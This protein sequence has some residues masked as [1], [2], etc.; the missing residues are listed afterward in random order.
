M[1][2]E[3]KQGDYLAGTDEN[4][5]V[6]NRT[7][8]NRNNAERAAKMQWKRLQR[9]AATF[10]PLLAGERADLYTEM[11]DKVSGFEQP[12]DDAEWTIPRERKRLVRIRT[13]LLL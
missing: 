3:A 4:V 13:L 8:A 11:L 9:G 5:F 10:I 6:L 1:G 7:Y 12:I 2:P